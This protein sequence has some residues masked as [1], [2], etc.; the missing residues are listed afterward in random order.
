M[1]ILIVST[2]IAHNVHVLGICV[3]SVCV[4]IRYFRCVGSA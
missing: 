4:A 2:L 1:V 3:F